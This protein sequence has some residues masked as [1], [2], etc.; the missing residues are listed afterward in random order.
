LSLEN[1]RKINKEIKF[2]GV[3]SRGNRYKRGKLSRF[4]E[5][6]REEA[7]VGKI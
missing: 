1:T 3:E 5:R 7:E 2:V 6:E 4:R